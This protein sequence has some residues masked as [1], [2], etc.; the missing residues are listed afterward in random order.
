MQQRDITSSDAFENLS[1][2]LSGVSEPASALKT[3]RSDLETLH[4]L[5]LQSRLPQSGTAVGMVEKLV[6]L[7][8]QVQKGSVEPEVMSA[9]FKELSA[10]LAKIATQIR[11]NFV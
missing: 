10:V 9:P 1:R 8:Q 11:N 6:A 3:L 2:K 5:M 4:G 7:L